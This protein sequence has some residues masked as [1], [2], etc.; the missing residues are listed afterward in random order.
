M[1]NPS[2]WLR[3]L[4]REALAEA[5]DEL[6]AENDRNGDVVAAARRVMGMADWD[7]LEIDELPE[8]EREGM[9]MSAHEIIKQPA[10]EYVVSGLVREQ[11]KKTVRDGTEERHY[12]AGRS[13]I[14]G[15]SLVRETLSRMDERF[16]AL[17]EE[18]DYDKDSLI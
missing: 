15:I 4:Y 12:L 11:A 14:M 17:G 13:A 18:D 6:R 2:D 7:V 1:W 5:K 3:R 8:K 16:K 9:L 10:L